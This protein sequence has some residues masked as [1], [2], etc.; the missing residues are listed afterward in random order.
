METSFEKLG[1]F[2]LGKEYDMR[3][4]KVRTSTSCT[5]PKT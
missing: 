1:L 3:A 4:G 5:T 2:Y